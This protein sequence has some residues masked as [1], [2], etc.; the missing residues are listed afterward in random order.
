MTKMHT[1]MIRLRRRSDIKVI[2][3]I[4]IIEASPTDKD[5]D[6]S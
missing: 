3:A 6:E 4:V 5:D 1:Y 2:A